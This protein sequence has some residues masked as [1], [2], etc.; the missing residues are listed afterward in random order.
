MKPATC[1]RYR[2]HEDLIE[3]I[4]D[5]IQDETDTQ[6]H[7]YSI[8]EINDSLWQADGPASINHTERILD[9]TEP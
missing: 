9:I 5:D 6:E 4:F 7:N 1:N 2:D 8:T 3:E